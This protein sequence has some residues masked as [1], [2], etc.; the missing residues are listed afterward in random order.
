MK[1]EI[2]VSCH[3]FQRRMSWMISS[4][5][6][7]LGEIP[8]LVFNVAYDERTGNPTTEQTLHFFD[9][10]PK[11]SNIVID[12]KHTPYVGTETLQYRGLVRNRQLAESDADFIFFSDCDMVFGPRWFEK[13]LPFLEENKN[14]KRMF[15]TGRYS[16]PVGDADK[17][18]AA[19]KY[20]Y[21]V[22]DPFGKAKGARLKK[23][24]N[25]GA[26]F[27]QI[28]SVKSMRENFDGLYIPPNNCRDYSW[29]KKYQKAKSD[30]T[31]RRRVGRVSMPLPYLYHLNHIRDNDTKTHTEVQR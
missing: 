22:R 13:L 9:S 14:D 5:L 4:L 10:L 21:R 29:E 11:S 8:Q 15:Y 25:C 2:A 16:M 24:R 19:H 1:V 3:Y 7:Q 18:V 30:V 27:C 31:F 6:E 12:F 26:G 23:R 28:V 20:P 17:L